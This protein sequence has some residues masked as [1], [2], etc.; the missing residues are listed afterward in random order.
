MD[1]P[2]IVFFFS[3]LTPLVMPFADRSTEGG[4]FLA[5]CPSLHE[6]EGREA[7]L[8]LGCTVLCGDAGSLAVLDDG[9]GVLLR[10]EGLHEGGKNPEG[11]FP[12]FFPG[13]LLCALSLGKDLF[14]PE[15]ARLLA[16]GGAELL[17][18]VPPGSEDRGLSKDFARVRAAENQIFT[19]LLRPFPE[20][21]LFFGPGGEA[22]PPVLSSEGGCVILHK[23]ALGRARKALPLAALRQPDLYHGITAL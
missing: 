5:L 1:A 9:G 22:L 6:E 10:Y 2:L 19:A 15:H 20:G 7:A 16:L 3:S 23:G 12:L 4:G 8:A 11:A 17:L 13:G 18:C 21:P 14:F